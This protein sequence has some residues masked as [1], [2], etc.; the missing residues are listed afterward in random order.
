[1]GLHTHLNTQQSMQARQF[2]LIGGFKFHICTFQPWR[3]YGS[4][5]FAVFPL[6]LFVTTWHTHRLNR[7]TTHVHTYCERTSLMNSEDSNFPSATKDRKP[8]ELNYPC[9]TH[10]RRDQQR[11]HSRNAHAKHTLGRIF[12][13]NHRCAHTHTQ[14]LAH[15]KLL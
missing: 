15:L 7:L 5:V 8:S 2:K 3:C 11:A 6:F 13:R 14:I 1:M 9:L 12:S 4:S 10:A